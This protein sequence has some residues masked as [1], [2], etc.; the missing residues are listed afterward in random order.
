VS[1]SKGF[2]QTL[3]FSGKGLFILLLVVLS[4]AALVLDWLSGRALNPAISLTLPLWTSTLTAAGLG[5]WVIPLLRKLKAGQFIREDGPQ[6]HL[7]K[8]GTP[9]MG[10]IFFVPA[11]LSVA[12]VW[13]G[14]VAGA[15]PTEVLAVTALTLV[16]GFVGWLDDWQVLRRQSNQ[17]ISARLRLGLEVG[18]SLLFCLWL[19]EHQPDITTLA[20]PFGFALPLGFLFW[21]LAIFVATAESNAVNLTDGLDGLA[22]GTSAI[23]F[24]GLGALI[25]PTW[26]QLMIFCSCLSGG[27][28]GFLAHNYNPARVFMGDTGSLALGGALAAVGLISNTLWGLLILSGI[29]LVESLSV[30]AQV[31]YYKATK[32]PD[33]VGKRLFKMSPIHNHFELTGWPET[34]IVGVFYG[35]SGLLALLCLGLN[36]FS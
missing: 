7:K 11:A 33:G 16:F 3:A 26:P 36:Y 31:A 13:S 22:A 19:A 29:F 27:C 28:L 21:F 35:M 32:G 10:G 30:I 18:S 34:Q 17:G 2:Q 23:A 14:V 25:A 6:T 1:L 24:L 4:S 15:F 8:A 5:Y 20:F 12:V 9:T